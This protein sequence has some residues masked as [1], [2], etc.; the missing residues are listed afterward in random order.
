MPAAGRC[1]DRE[2]EKFAETSYN[3]NWRE[4]SRMEKANLL[5][6]DVRWPHN[7]IPLCFIVL[8]GR[9]GDYTAASHNNNTSAVPRV[10][11]GAERG[12]PGTGRRG[13]GCGVP[14]RGP[15]WGPGATAPFCKVWRG[16]WPGRG[17]CGLG[18][19]GVREAASTQPRQ[20]RFTLAKTGLTQ[21]R[22]VGRERGVGGFG[23]LRGLVG[24]RNINICFSSALNYRR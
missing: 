7:I 6:T 13:A 18:S 1:W 21:M 4:G 20:P 2:R 8:S 19:P 12:Q 17:R 5:L 3:K 23:E 16:W 22:R 10:E 9:R 14:S 15:G 24:S 11:A